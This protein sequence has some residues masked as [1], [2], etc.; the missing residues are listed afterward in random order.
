MSSSEDSDMP[1]FEN[2]DYGELGN[3][4]KQYN[5]IFKGLD[6]ETKKKLYRDFPNEKNTHIGILKN[7]SDPQIQRLW[8]SLSTKE[9][10]NLDSKNIRTKYI[11]LRDMLKTRGNPTEKEETPNSS[12]SSELKFEKPDTPPFFVNPGTPLDTPPPLFANPGTPE[13]T[14]P[15]FPL[16]LRLEEFKRKLAPESKELLDKIKDPKERQEDL[17]R[18]LKEY[19]DADDGGFVWRELKDPELVKIYNGLPSSEKTRL[20][21][22]G[23][24]EKYLNLRNRLYSNLLLKRHNVPGSSSEMSVAMVK[25]APQ[26][27]FHEEI[28]ELPKEKGREP[29]Q[30]QFDNIVKKFYNMNP[31]VF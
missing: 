22:L 24:K 2:V 16:S 17:M 23:P 14:P 9:R 8:S 13:G 15:S 1:N 29:P 12:S 20:D 19:E 21:S 30:K 10:E 31:Y 26:D 28:P 18:R 6:I 4:Y 27:M 7:I 3:E 5:A 25:E 11:M